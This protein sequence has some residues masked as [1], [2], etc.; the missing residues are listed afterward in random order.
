M[1]DESFITADASHT[2]PS[3]RWQA[4]VGGLVILVGLGMAF[5]AL[6]IPGNAGYGGVGPNF[7][8]WLCA[9]ALGLCG[10]LLVREALT[11][12]YRQAQ[13]P[14]GHAHAAWGPFVWVS[15][16]L[17]VNAALITELGFVL[18]C[19]LCYALAVQGLRRAGGEARTL[20]PRGLVLDVGTGL[21]ISAPVYWLFTKFLAIS[22]P[23]LTQTGWL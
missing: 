14:G 13:A 15:S 12:G 16:G 4:G 2:V 22:L 10:V 3:P 19:A 20:A 6:Q 7:L 8:P 11:G 23:G 9:A 5:G 17:L 1:A 21:V 18:A